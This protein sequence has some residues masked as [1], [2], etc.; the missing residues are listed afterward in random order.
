MLSQSRLLI[1]STSQV[2][3]QGK[4]IPGITLTSISPSE[5][6]FLV[7][8]L[9][10]SAVNTRRTSVQDEFAYK[11]DDWLFALLQLAPVCP[12]VRIR[13]K[14]KDQIHRMMV[15]ISSQTSPKGG[16]VGRRELG[17]PTSEQQ[18]QAYHPTGGMLIIDNFAHSSRPAAIICFASATTL[19]DCTPL[20]R[21]FAT[22]C[23]RPRCQH[24][25]S[26][27][28]CNTLFMTLRLSFLSPTTPPSSLE[29]RKAPAL[30][31]VS[32]SSRISAQ[33][34]RTYSLAT[35]CVKEVV[36]V[37]RCRRHLVLQPVVVP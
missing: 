2:T 13:R 19:Q 35:W 21:A 8:S 23:P 37:V 6:D 7:D 15:F 31:L 30:G 18:R 9:S 14:K 26:C 29:R 20:R 3:G 16:G 36:V 10:Y 33:V 11:C 17:L 27:T 24:S 32:P 5:R 25:A 12:Q 4:S 22:W 28:H 34:P 1:F